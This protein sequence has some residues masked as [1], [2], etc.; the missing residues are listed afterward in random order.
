MRPEA[1]ERELK[2]LTPRAPESNLDNRI[3]ASLG[4]VSPQPRAQP[5]PGNSP[6]DFSQSSYW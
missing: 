2:Q 5:A 4:H 1:I 3:R 6:P